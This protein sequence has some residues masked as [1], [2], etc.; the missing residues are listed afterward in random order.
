MVS[1]FCRWH[2]RD[3]GVWDDPCALF[4][5]KTKFADNAMDEK[6][7]RLIAQMHKAITIIQFKL[8]GEIIRRRPEFEMDDRML[9][10]HIDLKREWFISMERIIR[11]KI[12]TGLL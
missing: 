10:H 9:L 7:T 3:G 1:I 11:L 6:T 2:F 12:L 4:M 5:P 8:E